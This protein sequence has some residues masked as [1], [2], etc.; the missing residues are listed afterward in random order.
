[1][2]DSN[3]DALASGTIEA[4]VNGET[5]ATAEIG[6]VPGTDYSYLLAVPMGML[7]PSSTDSATG[8]ARPAGDMIGFLVNHQPAY[9]QDSSSNLTV[10]TWQAPPNA[11]GRGF[12]LNLSLPGALRYTL[13]DVNANG[14]SNVAD[15]MLTLKYDI[16]LI[17]GVTAFPPGPEH[18]LPAALRHRGKWPLRLQRCAA[19][20][21]V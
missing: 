17:I 4:V 15:A 3:G 6:G 2:T 21:P 13:G 19:H 20:P 18:R 14:A 12:M 7:P 8:V 11:P 16:G 9:F 1:M 10:N 5:L